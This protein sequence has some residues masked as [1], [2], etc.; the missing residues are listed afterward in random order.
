[1]CI[2]DRCQSETERLDLL[3]IRRRW[4]G[5]WMILWSFVRNDEI[6]GNTTAISYETKNSGAWR[7]SCHMPDFFCLVPIFINFLLKYSSHISTHM[8]IFSH[9][10][11]RHTLSNKFL[12]KYSSEPDSLRSPASLPPQNKCCKTNRK[13]WQSQA[14]VSGR[15]PCYTD[16]YKRQWSLRRHRVTL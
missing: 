6:I 3:I 2:R 12:L 16:V 8:E 15:F 10:P 1:M 9:L 4:R 13:S 5:R 7:S 11:A 14:S